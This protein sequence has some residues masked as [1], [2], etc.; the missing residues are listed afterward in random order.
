MLLFEALLCEVGNKYDFVL[1]VYDH[2]I[3]LSCMNRVLP[4]YHDDGRIA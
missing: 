4:F 2:F 1:L 3:H